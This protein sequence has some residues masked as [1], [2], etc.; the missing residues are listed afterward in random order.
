[1]CMC[2]V[3]C[4]VGHTV[5]HYRMKLQTVLL[6]NP[7][8]EPVHFTCDNANTQHFIVTGLPQGEVMLYVIEL[9]HQPYICTCTILT[10]GG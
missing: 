4:G 1:M 2:G 8:D 10:G 5:F 9:P 6:R 7:L 3:V